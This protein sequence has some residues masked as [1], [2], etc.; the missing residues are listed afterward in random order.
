MADQGSNTACTMNKTFLQKLGFLHETPSHTRVCPIGQG[1][2]GPQSLTSVTNLPVLLAG[3][4]PSLPSAT[5]DQGRA[6]RG[7]QHWACVRDHRGPVVTDQRGVVALSLG[8]CHGVQRARNLYLVLPGLCHGN[9]CQLQ[10]HRKP[11]T[12]SV[13]P[14]SPTKVV[15][16]ERTGSPES[17]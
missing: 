5:S 2:P 11:N 14:C 7:G 15:N 16:L 1:Q 17:A 12:S 8:C 13:V 4:Y 6:P 3:P 9:P 10:F